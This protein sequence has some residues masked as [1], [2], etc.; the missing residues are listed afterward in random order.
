[1]IKSAMYYGAAILVG[2]YLLGPATWP[3]SLWVAWMLKKSLSGRL[4]STKGLLIQGA[5]VAIAYAL[6]WKFPEYDMAGV[7]AGVM[8]VMLF[9]GHAIAKVFGFVM[10]ESGPQPGIKN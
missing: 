5:M 3:V 2:F 6:L 4:P 10:V 8:I 9:I 1:M 7:G